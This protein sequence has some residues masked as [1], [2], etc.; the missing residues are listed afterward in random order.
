MYS[1]LDIAK[2]I[3]SYCSKKDNPVSNLKLQ[4]LLYFLWVDYYK[5]TKSK[6]FDDY[7]CAWQLGPVVPEVYYEFC[8]Y[9]GIPINKTFDCNV[10]DLKQKNILETIIEK[11]ID[12]SAYS[13]VEKTHQEGTPWSIIYNNG[14][15]SK[16]IIPFELILKLECNW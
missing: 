1:A 7:I 8:S 10:E 13:L 16:E 2:Y 3:I 14:S 5:E 4:K 9:A 11:Y 12:T 15:G 6:L